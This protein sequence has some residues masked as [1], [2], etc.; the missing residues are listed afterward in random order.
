MT[1]PAQTSNELTFAYQV[2]YI[3]EESFEPPAL[4]V[5]QDPTNG[6]C[7]WFECYPTIQPDQSTGDVLAT[8]PRS[9][10]A[11]HVPGVGRLCPTLQTDQ[12]SPPTRIAQTFPT[13]VDWSTLDLE[14]PQTWHLGSSSSHY[15]S[16]SDSGLPESTSSVYQTLSRPSSEAAESRSTSPQV[17]LSTVENRR[18]RRQQ[19]NRKA[20]RVYRERQAM[21]LVTAKEQVRDLTHQLEELHRTNSAL[22]ATTKNLSDQVLLLKTTKSQA[23]CW[24]GGLEA[25]TPT[26]MA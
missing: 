8:R 23:P 10:G 18:K 5:I 12:N 9:I 13:E 2:S 4:D 24:C 3:A 17:S 7:A 21:V 15:D 20:Q 14:F 19:Q 16:F 26:R 22:E 11:L 1:G 6:D 25:L